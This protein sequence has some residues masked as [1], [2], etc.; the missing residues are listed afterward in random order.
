MRAT[1]R[2]ARR[3]REPGGEGRA[4]DHPPASADQA[5][6]AAGAPAKGPAR[7][8][9]AWSQWAGAGGRARDHWARAATAAAS[10]T[11]RRP[12]GSDR[13]CPAAPSPDGSSRRGRGRWRSHARG[14]ARCGPR[15]RRGRHHRRLWRAA[16]RWRRGTTA[17][18]ASG[19]GRSRT[20]QARRSSQ[21]PHR[22]R[23]HS[24]EGSSIT[25]EL[26]A[27][28]GRTALA[29]PRDGA[30]RRAADGAGSKGSAG[31]Q[32]PRLAGSKGADDGWG[33]CGR[34]L[35]SVGSATS[36]A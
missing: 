25:P 8:R 26:S 1:P 19:G 2:D 11:Q 23:F 34:R 14:E 13:R 24:V 20:A 3:V 16:W 7:H 32:T 17:A 22:A 6:C 29:A 10:C 15:N 36:S 30:T 4:K 18:S 12:G 21:E 28:T 9:G 33:W 5:R 31:A 27:S 35:G